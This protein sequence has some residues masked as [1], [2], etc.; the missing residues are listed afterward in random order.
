MIG[1]G[2]MAE[3]TATPAQML[4]NGGKLV[5]CTG[6]AVPGFGKASPY[7]PLL[8]HPHCQRRLDSSLSMLLPWLKT[9]GLHGNT[10]SRT[11]CVLADQRRLH[12]D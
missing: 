4:A 8:V 1:I 2:E 10:E 7:W 6:T 12:L 3:A 9:R 11:D 5:S